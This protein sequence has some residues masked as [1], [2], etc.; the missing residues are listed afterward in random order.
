MSPAKKKKSKGADEE[1]L[2]DG[3]DEKENLE[4]GDED[5][6]WEELAEEE[7]EGDGDETY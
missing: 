3:Y 7:L 6:S 4:D 1:E 2:I 5:E